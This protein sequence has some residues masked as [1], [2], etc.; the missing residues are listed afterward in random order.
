MAASHQRSLWIVLQRGW[1][2]CPRYVKKPSW[3]C[4]KWTVCPEGTRALHN[5][6]A[7]HDSSCV[8]CPAGKYAATDPNGDKASWLTPY[9]EPTLCKDLSSCSGHEGVLMPGTRSNDAVCVD[10]GPVA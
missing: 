1:S 6:T 9:V 7:A 3:N 5:G 10:C 8:A 4:K 2:L